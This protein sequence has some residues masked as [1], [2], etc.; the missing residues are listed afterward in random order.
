MLPIN[1]PRTC[2]AV[3]VGSLHD[4]VLEH[5]VD[6][7]WK[8]VGPGARLRIEGESLDKSVARGL[9]LV[10][11]PMPTDEQKSALYNQIAAIFATASD[12][13]AALRGGIKITL[14]NAESKGILSETG[15]D[16]LGIPLDY[17]IKVDATDGT[18]TIH[19]YCEG[20]EFA[21]STFA[22]V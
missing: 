7:I 3:P 14:S 15:L 11:I 19:H 9:K 13:Q 22:V 1:Q 5:T 4:R 2:G 16:I 21:Q 20:T 17:S 8:N 6:A 18:L 12:F 10:K